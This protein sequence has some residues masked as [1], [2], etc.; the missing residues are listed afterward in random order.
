MV[1]PA[2]LTL[3]S[4]CSRL[5]AAASSPPPWLPTL[6]SAGHPPPD[7]ARHLHTSS[8]P[9][10]RLHPTSTRL[11]TSSSVC[12]PPPRLPTLLSAGHPPPRLARLL[13]R[14]LHVSGRRG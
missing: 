11:P 8:P 14:R 6:F 3:P 4:A 5:T 12:H 1:F 9:C 13:G 10:R 2:S 7:L